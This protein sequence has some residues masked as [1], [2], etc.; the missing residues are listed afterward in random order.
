MKIESPVL[1]RLVTV[2]NSE[3][4]FGHYDAYADIM[5]ENSSVHGENKILR[6]RIREMKTVP[7]AQV[8]PPSRPGSAGTT[9]FVAKQDQFVQASSTMTDRATDPDPPPDLQQEPQ[10]AR[11]VVEQLLASRGQDDDDRAQLSQQVERYEVHLLDLAVQLDKVKG[12]L[13]LVSDKHVTSTF[14]FTRREAD[15]TNEITRK[16]KN[17]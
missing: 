15:L 17:L 9:A 4:L 1:E 5:N 2:L 16:V 3:R 10:A 8:S 7:P 11:P 12:E 6:E 13:Q 14:E